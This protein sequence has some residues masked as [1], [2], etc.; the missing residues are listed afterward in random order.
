MKDST[1]SALQAAVLP[2]AKIHHPEKYEMTL[3]VASNPK[4]FRAYLLRLL[5]IRYQE[6]AAGR[7]ELPIF[8]L[9]ETGL[10]ITVRL[11]DGRKVQFQGRQVKDRRRKIRELAMPPEE[12]L[13]FE[14]TRETLDLYYDE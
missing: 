4:S 7:G 10:T 11:K 5:E 8:A 9:E 13:A 1:M 14:H 2:W 3:K 6:D 12:W